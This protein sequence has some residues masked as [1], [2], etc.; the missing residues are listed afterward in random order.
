MQRLLKVVQSRK[1]D[2]VAG[3]YVIG[4]WFVVQAGSIALP[5]FGA[6]AWTLRALIAGAVIGL[7]ITLAAA[8]FAQAH[9]HPP[10]R[11]SSPAGRHADMALLAGVILVSAAIAAEF[12]VRW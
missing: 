6:P 4:S 7:P 9:A 3:L 2:R 5:A 8:W 1:I 10:R 12:L 11:G